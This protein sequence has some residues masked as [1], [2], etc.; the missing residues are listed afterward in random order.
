MVDLFKR[1]NIYQSGQRQIVFK[2]ASPFAAV[3]FVFKCV[4]FNP[5]HSLSP[6]CARSLI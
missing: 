1:G 4:S 5:A 6:D 3:S 2:L